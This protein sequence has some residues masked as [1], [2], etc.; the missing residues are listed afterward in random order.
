[1]P[2][3]IRMNAAVANPSAA[4]IQTIASEFCNKIQ[5]KWCCGFDPDMATVDDAVDLEPQGGDGDGV[6]LRAFA[7]PFRLV[8]PWW[9]ALVRPRRAGRGLHRY[10][11]ADRHAAVANRATPPASTGVSADGWRWSRAGRQAAAP[12]PS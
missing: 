9:R 3:G 1:M 11:L 12:P 5:T 10:C 8:A 7:E 4:T 6:Q 2:S